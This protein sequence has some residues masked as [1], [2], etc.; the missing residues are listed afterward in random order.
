MVQMVAALVTDGNGQLSFN[1]NKWQ[2]INSTRRRFN[3]ATAATTLN[4]VGAGVTAPV[5]VQLKQLQLQAVA[6]PTAVEQFKINYAT[7]G[8]LPSIS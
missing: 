2:F 4:F 8:N 5:Q 7:N 6:V 1:N 3:Y